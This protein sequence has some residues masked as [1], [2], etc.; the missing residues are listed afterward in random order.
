MVELITHY[1]LAFVFVNVLL[2]R[3]GLPLP[4]TPAVLVA[5]ALG[6]E[7]RFP[8][9]GVFA[10]AFVGCLLGDALWYAAGWYYGRR[11]ISMLCRISLSPNSCVRQ[12]ES[13][14]E[15]WGPL[16]LIVAKFVP[17][18]ST[19]VRPLAGTLHMGWRS[20]VALDG[21]G[22]ALWVLVAMWVGIVF[23][24]QVGM[25]LQRLQEV[26][27]GAFGF[28][29]GLIVAYVA[30]K[31]WERRRFAKLMRVA[32]IEVAELRRLLRDSQPA[33]APIVVDLRS[34]LGRQLDRRFI[35]GS[36]AMRLEEVNLRLDELPSH[37]EIVFF[38]ACPQEATAALA[39]RKLLD[40]G[41]TQVRVLSGGIDAWGALG[42]EALGSGA[43]EVAPPVSAQLP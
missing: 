5:A 37:R 19:V 4:A 38:C 3:V 28:V 33:Q 35:P 8:L 34:A 16:T 12:T 24:A 26:G 41:H 15:R 1:G 40:L 36:I 2:E 29:L 7:G 21:L 11:V 30:F 27:P 10:V 17:G 20:F 43:L 25:L 22:S 39:A 18:L 31:W 23:H 13:R 9:T 6:M 14:F 32:R 42:S